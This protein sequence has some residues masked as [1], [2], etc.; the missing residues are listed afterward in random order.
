[1][2]NLKYCL[3]FCLVTF[4]VLFSACDNIFNP[5][6]DNTS[7]GSV[8]SDQLTIDGLYQNFRYA[9]TFKDTSVYSGVLTDDFVFT[10]RDYELGYD[11][12]W[13]KPTELRTTNGL[14]QNSQKLEIIW[15]NIVLQLGDSLQ[16]NV[17][18]S[19]NLTIT[20]NPSDIVRV[21]GF[22]DMNLKRNS[23]TD[24]W[25]ISRWRDESF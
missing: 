1:M 25:R 16:M 20:F 23:S 14:F 21:N 18:R 4:A 5:K 15:N 2:I 6:L 17:K 24:K 11:V 7:T 22:A 8:I 9:F 3:F 19:F 12:S 13:D 10:Y